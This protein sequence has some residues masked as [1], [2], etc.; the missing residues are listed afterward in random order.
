MRGCQYIIIRMLHEG[1]FSNGSANFS[2]SF[3]NCIW[4]GKYMVDAGR[5]K[6]R[7]SDGSLDIDF[8]DCI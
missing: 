2:Q 8:A 6:I 4:S 5:C 3:N 7:L 1:T